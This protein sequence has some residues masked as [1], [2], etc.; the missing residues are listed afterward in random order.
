M[1]LLFVILDGAADRKND[2][3]NGMTPLQSANMPNLRHLAS[4]SIKGMMYPIGKGVAPESDAAVFS[5][6]GY[7]MSAYT[8]RG[9]LEAYGAGMEV[10]DRSVA[11]RCNFATINA[12]R[13]IIDR[14]AGRIETGDA[15]A[16]EKE[17][18]EIDLGIKGI[19]FKFKSTVGHRGAC[20]FYSEKS[21]SANVSNADIGYVRKGNISVAE[22]VASKKLPKVVPLDES[23]ASANTAYIVNAFIDKVIEKLAHSKVNS[24]RG[25]EGLL[26]ANALLLRDA[27]VGL[28]KV[29]T[30]EARYGMKCAFIAE[31]PVET[32]I[33]KVLGMEPIGLEELK[34]RKG[35]YRRMAELVIQNL[36]RYDFMYVHIKGPDEPG[37]DGDALLK[38][39]ILEEIDSEF[40]SRIRE[41][42]VDM[43]VT[44]DHAT[45][46]PLKA[47]SSDPVPVMVRYANSTKADA[48]DFDE[49]IDSHGTMRIMNGNQLVDYII[50]RRFDAK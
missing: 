30:F 37:H 38:K 40:F 28:P 11:F 23:E 16:L 10:D 20:V 45:P 47:H 9:P 22:E 21:L 50:K 14:R 49:N 24:R 27:G 26:R 1:A 42:D 15:K 4:Q 36:S 31:M 13:D 35:R 41:L 17:I 29:E 5:I 48:V 3:L 7:D 46:C 12:D 6:L 39:K 18:S 25:D 19:T 34:D 2:A 8:G 32:G 43:C 33:A 44:C